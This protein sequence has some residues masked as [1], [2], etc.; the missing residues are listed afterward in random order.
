MKPY[1][2]TFAC[3]IALL[4]GVACGGR[5]TTASKSAA[6]YDEARRNGQQVSAGEHG[7]HENAPA[8]A[9]AADATQPPMSGMDHS[10]M[11]GM[12]HVHKNGVDHFAMHGMDHPSMPGMK[13]DT[14]PGMR[15]PT[16]DKRHATSEHGAMPAMQHDSMAGMAHSS[17]PGMDHAAMP[18]MDHG[19][20]ASMH[21]ATPMP[22][23]LAAPASSSAIGATQPASTLRQD[24]F[25]APAKSAVDDAAKA[26]SGM[27]HH[28]D[29]GVR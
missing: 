22:L 11:T 23:P 17:M 27:R 21:H 5:Q 14:M 26:T 28:G 12:N 24:E 4:A 3:G 16:S 9:S 19:A 6:A 20:M 25:D 15:P 13:H 8:T 29:G 18:G 7:G 10:T 1:V 2:R